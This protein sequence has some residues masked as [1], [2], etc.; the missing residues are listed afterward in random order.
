VNSPGSLMLAL[1]LSLAAGTARPPA[2]SAPAAALT[3]A[4]QVA[5][6]AGVDAAKC[7]VPA[8]ELDKL[9]PYRWH[10]AQYKAD[11][12]FIPDGTI[13]IDYCELIGTD[14]KG[15]M[16]TG[17]MVNIARGANAEAFARHWHAVCAD[18]LM[19]DARGTVQPLPGV[20]GGH[21]CVTP[22]GSSSAYWLESAGRTIQVEAESD[23][24]DWAEIL[25]RLLAAAR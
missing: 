13:R 9:T 17:V 25:P 3:A 7:P 2:T 8:A 12:G 19:P 11:R 4:G 22:K 1:V 21:Q 20:P 16:R 18:S 24:A 5:G 15:S 6:P 10:V 14:N 23:G